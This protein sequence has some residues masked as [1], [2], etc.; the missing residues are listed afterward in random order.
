MNAK[1][2]A[3]FVRAYTLTLFILQ[4]GVFSLAMTAQVSHF[5]EPQHRAA[6]AMLT[7]Y[8]A[9]GLAELRITADRPG[10]GVAESRTLAVYATA[11]CATWASAA[12]GP[13]P[14][15]GWSPWMLI[16]IATFATGITVRLTAIHTL[17]RFYSHHVRRLDDHH[18]VTTGPYR[19]VRHPAYTGMAL[20]NAGFVAFF[21]NP[22]SLT[23]LLSLLLA[24]VWRIRTEEQLLWHI[25]GYPAYATGRPRLIP[26]VW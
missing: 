8:L 6:A 23:A 1:N 19:L 17:G 13:L 20:A 14:W 21:C 12:L 24:L 22:L 9:W 11:R 5:D 2:T 3:G 18:I 16:P 7:A 4:L 26:G 10:E 25:P 15:T